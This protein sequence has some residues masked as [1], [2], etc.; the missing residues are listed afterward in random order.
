VRLVDARVRAVDDDE[1][2]GREVAGLAVEDH[3]RHL[4][5]AIG[6]LLL[7]VE[8][9]AGEAVLAVDDQEV[10]ARFDEVAGALHALH[11]LELELL[12]RE[13]Q[14]RARDHRLARLVAVEVL[15]LRIFLRF[16]SRW[17]DL[18]FFSIAC[19]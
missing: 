17:N 12:R 18:L 8:V 10:A 15:D 13:Q 19:T 4:D 6:V 7:Q 11:G 16:R 2:L 14:H 5:A 3:D 1:H 9:Q